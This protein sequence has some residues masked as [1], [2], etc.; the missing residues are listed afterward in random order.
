MADAYRKVGRGGA[1]NFYSQKDIDEAAKPS[2]ST[3]LEAQ[4]PAAADEPPSDPAEPPAEG[5]P[6]TST[7]TS[8]TGA[9]SSTPVYSRTGRGGAG[10]FVD[11]LTASSAN[12]QS[13]SKPHPA[14]VHSV[15]NQSF[16]P[17]S[18]ER[19]PRAGLSGRGGAGNWTGDESQKVFD[20]EQ[21][22]KRK[23]ALDAKVFDDVKAGLQEPGRAHTRVHPHR[24]R[25]GGSFGRGFEEV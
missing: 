9:A 18:T 23:A 25:G 19:G 4:K 16:A 6:S 2:G 12:I 24:G 13:H 1:G 17:G 10:N 22:R 15:G 7:S 21:E 8:T 11:P 5:P 14:T 3:D 20:E